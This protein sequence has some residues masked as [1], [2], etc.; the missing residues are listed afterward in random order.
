ML[1]TPSLVDKNQQHPQP[2]SLPQKQERRRMRISQSHPEPL[3]NDPEPQPHPP[4]PPKQLKR[5]M[6]QI[7]EQQ[8][9]LPHKNPERLFEH[10]QSLLPQPVAAKSLIFASIFLGLL[11]I[12]IKFMGRRI[13]HANGRSCTSDYC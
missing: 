12:Y 8:S 10:P 9:P 2:L 6:S 7:K 3:D 5:R 4:L 13:N 11:L 1:G